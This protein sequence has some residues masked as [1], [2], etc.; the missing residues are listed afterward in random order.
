MAVLSL[1]SQSEGWE[2]QPWS[3]VEVHVAMTASG[4]AGSDRL[5]GLMAEVGSHLESCFWSI[6]A[7]WECIIFI[8]GASEAVAGSP[9][10][11]VH[12]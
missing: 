6:M 1:K 7:V 11:T 5:L 10:Y 8:C 2:I 12:F 3:T 4:S 9:S